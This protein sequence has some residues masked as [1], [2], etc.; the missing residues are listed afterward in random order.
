MTEKNRGVKPALS[1]WALLAKNSIYKVTAV[2]LCMAAAEGILFYG[3][4]MQ[5]EPALDAALDGSHISGVFLAAL[6]LTVFILA[7]TQ[8]R[9]DRQSGAV[10]GRLRLSRRG[11]YL[12]RTAYNILCMVLLFAVQIWLCILLITFYGKET[13]E[14][15][16]FPQRLFLAFY[17]SEFLHC[18]LPM[19]EAGKWVRNIL[20]ILALGTETAA[21]RGRKND[22]TLVLLYAV[23]AGLFVS[24]LGGGM[25]DFVCGV[26]YAAVT[27]V[28]VWRAWKKADYAWT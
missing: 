12:L 9:L 27:A 18:L 21:G 5:G 13:A 11:I 3:R 14:G 23:T 17:R 22:M 4:V 1:L 16:V 28:N 20:L 7:W 26:V 8:G 25:G 24:S 15:R 6:G 2:L 10:M 19:A